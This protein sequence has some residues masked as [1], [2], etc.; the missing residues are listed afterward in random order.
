ML[1]RNKFRDAGQ[2]EA[3]VVDWCY[4]FYNHQRRHGT[5][6]RT[7]AVSYEIREN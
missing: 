7:I 4:T 6:R 2:A 5:A 3:V 1:Y